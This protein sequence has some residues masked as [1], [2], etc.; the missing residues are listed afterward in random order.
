MSLGILA[1][2]GILVWLIVRGVN[3]KYSPFLVW[4]LGFVGGML[5]WLWA[6]TVSGV[7]VQALMYS[8]LGFIVG[9]PV[10]RWRRAR[11]VK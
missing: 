6:L 10:W 2:L 9:Y 4:F 11:A 8:W 3:S 7:L 1:G 5:L